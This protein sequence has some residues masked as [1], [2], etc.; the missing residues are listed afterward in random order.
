MPAAHIKRL[1][2]LS[3]HESDSDILIQWQLF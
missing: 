1:R 3:H 2:V